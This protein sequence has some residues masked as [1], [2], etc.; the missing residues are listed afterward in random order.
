MI[1]MSDKWK[2]CWF[3]GFKLLYFM[4]FF[5]LFI[6]YKNI[7]VEIVNMFRNKVMINKG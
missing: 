4:F 7:D 5:L 3:K 1:N 6:D 2:L